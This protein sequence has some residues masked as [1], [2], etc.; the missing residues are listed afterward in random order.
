MKPVWMVLPALA[1]LLGGGLRAQDTAPSFPAGEGQAAVQTACAAC[2]PP[3][4]VAGKRYDADK[5]AEVVDQ[6]I[7]KGAKVSDADYDVIVAYLARNYG[8]GK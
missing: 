3:A 4:I 1:A 5:W 6:M 2:H 7:G 8:V